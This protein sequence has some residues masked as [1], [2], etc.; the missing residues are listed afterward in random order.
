MKWFSNMKITKKLI[1]TFVIIAIISSVLIGTVGLVNINKINSLSS[2]MFNENLVPLR[3][4]YR[5]EVNFLYMRAAIKDMALSKQADRSKY[6]NTINDLQKDLL[7][8]LDKYAQSIATDEEKKNYDL[9]LADWKEYVTLRDKAVN[10]LMDNKLDEALVLIRAERTAKIAEELETYINTAFDLNAG[11]AENRNNTSRETGNTAIILMLVIIALAIVLSI[12]LGA[13]IAKAISK[14]INKLMIAADSIASG[15]LDVDIAIDSRDEVGN[16]AQA[17]R[18]IINSLENLIKDA[19]MLSSS[20]LE[21][22][23]DTRADASK[24]NGDYRKIV[25]GVNAT[26]D[27]VILPVNEAEQVMKKMAVNDYTVD[28]KGQYKGLL[29]EFAES[30]NNV[31][32]RLLSM[33]DVVVLVSKGD[34]SRL[35]EFQKL[36]KRSENDK[37]VPSFIQMMGTIRNLIQEAS[38]LATAAVNGELSIRGN[39]GKFEGGYAE[40]IEGMNRTMDAV[41]APLQ[42]S[43]NVMQEMKKG[44][45]TVSMTGDYK[46]EYARMKEALNLSIQSFNDVLN[47]INS[48]AQQVATGARQVSDSAQALSQ[49]STEQAS[50]VEELT[51]SLEEVSVQTKQNAENANQANELSIVA[52]E[53]AAQGNEQMQGML[54][55]M[56]EISESSSN[57]SKIIKVIDEIAFQTNILALNAAVEAARAGQHGKGF[58]V[59][60]EEVRNLAAR[61]ANAAKETTGLIEGSIKKSEGGTRIAN[62]TAI[63]LN[64]IVDGVAKAA[65]LVG[66]IAS[67]SNEQAVAIAQ[68]NQGIMQVSQVTQTNSATSEES[69]AASEELSSQAEILNELVSK[70]NLKK[71]NSSIKNLDNLSPEVL[72]LLENMNEKK[73]FTDSHAHEKKAEHKESKITIALSDNEFGKY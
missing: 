30:I 70:F 56:E 10:L 25:E 65:S 55:A 16:L 11:H 68:I 67:A 72:R 34:T 26:L 53:N 38:K 39:V 35:E 64:K 6:V 49:G 41:A 51:A 48:S 15:N 28:I 29:G 45:L 66:E 71:D 24:H 3:P 13:F 52:K 1:S 17:F 47:E 27:A 46:G 21:G 43:A 20:A 22:K 57:I 69:A 32:S 9:I 4:I 58:A 19:N 37:L 5:V 14:P 2:A 54:K 40:V 18:K 36:G 8:N 42:E 44:N 23:L 60:A 63:A 33:Q 50:A 61:S 7:L 59:V 12:V 73:R 62:E 31:R